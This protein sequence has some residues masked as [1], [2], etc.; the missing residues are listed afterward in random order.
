MKLYRIPAS[1]QRKPLGS[2]RA[3][4]QHELG[5]RY[6]VSA[7]VRASVQRA[8]AGQGRAGGRPARPPTSAPSGLQ[9]HAQIS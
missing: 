3:I 7:D 6:T 2:R 1:K 5:S 9:T 4:P 8:G